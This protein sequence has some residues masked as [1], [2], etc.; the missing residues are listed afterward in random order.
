MSAAS[1]PTAR[2]ISRSSRWR[3]RSC[4][5]RSFHHGRDLVPE[6]LR[7]ALLP[8]LDQLAE[9]AEQIKHYQKLIERRANEAY[10]EETQALRQ[11]AGV[12]PI[13]AL[14]FVVALDDPSRVRSGGAVASYLGL[15]PRQ[16]QSGGCDPQL[17]ITKAGNGFLRRLLVSSAQYILGRFGP[18]SDLRRWGL[19]LAARGGRGAKKRAVV[20]VARKLATLLLRLWCTGEPYDPL[21]NSRLRG[22]DAGRGLATGQKHPG[23]PSKRTRMERHRVSVCDGYERAALPGASFH[24]R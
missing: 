8:L 5:A 18:D 22:E 23:F 19:R 3:I 7:P 16:Q 24:E 14:A 12:G 21:R 1:S 15:R 17:G 20:A 10:R 4:S 2:V 6:A 11:V 9:L 13:T